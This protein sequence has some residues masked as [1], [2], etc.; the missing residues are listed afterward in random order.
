MDNYMYIYIYIYAY[1]C[2]YIPFFHYFSE[3]ELAVVDVE[4]NCSSLSTSALRPLR[5]PGIVNARGV[6]RERE[7]ERERD[8]VRESPQNSALSS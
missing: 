3:R 6:R 1:I 7:R 4:A 8:R 5:R 2:I